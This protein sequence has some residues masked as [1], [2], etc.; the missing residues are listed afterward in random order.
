[1]VAFFLL[2]LPQQAFQSHGKS[3]SLLSRVLQRLPMTLNL[4]AICRGMGLLHLNFVE[5]PLHL[6]E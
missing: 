1:V 3:A 2:D 6:L 4:G 5:L